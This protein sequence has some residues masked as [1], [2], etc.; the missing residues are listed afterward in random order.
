MGINFYHFRSVRTAHEKMWGTIAGLFQDQQ[1]ASRITSNIQLKKLAIDEL[2][3][4]KLLDTC[5]LCESARRRAERLWPDGKPFSLRCAYCFANGKWASQKG[6]QQKPHHVAGSHYGCYKEFHDF[7][8][9]YSPSSALE[10]IE[11]IRWI[12]R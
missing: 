1:L 4:P 2:R 7:L 6:V 12:L 11:T 8:F 3:F 5:V 9:P 10:A